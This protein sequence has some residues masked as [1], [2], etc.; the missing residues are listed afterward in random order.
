M[1]L[2]FSL[3]ESTRIR[4]RHDLELTQFLLHFEARLFA[5]ECKAY[6]MTQGMPMFTRSRNG[7]TWYGA[8]ARRQ[9]KS[10]RISPVAAGRHLR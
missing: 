5:P 3:R 8:V 2:E 4:T 7:P 6:G 10:D 9:S 1:V